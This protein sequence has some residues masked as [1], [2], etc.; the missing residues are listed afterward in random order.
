MGSNFTFSHQKTE[1]SES[2]LIC[3][4]LMFA[5]F[6]LS[7][8]FSCLQIAKAFGAS[9]IIAVDVLDEKLHNAKMLGAT[10]T[11][12]GLKEDVVDKIKVEFAPFFLKLLF[13]AK[14][15]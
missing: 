14:W 8:H 1:N 2:V 11:I 3:V 4:S 5:L 7:V 13:P 12:N 15:R 6:W 10:H 9:E